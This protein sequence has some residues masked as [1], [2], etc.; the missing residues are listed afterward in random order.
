VSGQGS[1]SHPGLVDSWFLLSCQE[2]HATTINNVFWSKKAPAHTFAHGFEDEVV[3]EVRQG[4]DAGHVVVRV[5][6]HQ[7]VRAARDTSPRSGGSLGHDLPAT[8]QVGGCRS[9]NMK[10]SY[11]ALLYT[12][13]NKT[14]VFSHYNCYHWQ[15]TK[16][17]K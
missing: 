2:H 5:H 1:N 9:F 12:V 16:N 13:G 6:D 15:L 17:C 11:L 3:E 14:V 8:S 4:D 10:H 7:T